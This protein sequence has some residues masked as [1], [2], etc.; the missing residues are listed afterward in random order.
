[1]QLLAEQQVQ[2]EVV[3]HLQQRCAMLD[4]AAASSSLQLEAARKALAEQQ[5]Q[6]EAT[7]DLQ[8]RTHSRL[9]Q[10]MAEHDHVRGRRSGRSAPALTPVRS[11][12]DGRSRKCV[13]N[14]A[15]AGGGICG[16]RRG[17]VC[18]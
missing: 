6:L 7:V 8:G 17:G 13:A 10:L 3:Q 9:M 12:A 4:E 18:T 1:V 5:Q 15:K 14:V 16:G 11:A 2:G